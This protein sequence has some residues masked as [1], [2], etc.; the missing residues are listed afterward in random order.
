MY[1]TQIS[2]IKTLFLSAWYPNR[3]D[4]MFGLF[5]FKQA[6]MM[7][8]Y[9]DVCAIFIYADDKIKKTEIIE[10]N[11]NGFVEIKVYYPKSYLKF[12]NVIAFIAAYF[13]VLKYL[14]NK[15]WLPD[16]IHVNVLTRTGFIAYLY[17]VFTKKP[18]II[19]EHWS[20]YLANNNTFKGF[21]RKKITKL[22]VKNASAVMPVSNVLK[23]AMLHHNLKNNN[24]IVVNNIV[25]DFFF[26]N[27]GKQDRKIKR[28]LHIS[29]FDERAKN[30]C[31]L[32]DATKLLSNIRSDFELVLIGTGKDF[33][34]CYQHYKNLGF[35]KKTVIFLG[36]IPPLKVSQELHNADLSVIFSNYETACISVIESLACGVPIIGTPTGIMPETIN[37][38][39]GFIVNFN[40]VIDL[41]NKMNFILNNL[42]NYNHNEIRENAKI[43][44]YES[45][46]KQL[47]EIYKEAL[48][49]DT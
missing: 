33:E 3:Y 48:K 5:A 1:N 27:T 30:I 32:L 18:Y 43:F 23:N 8:N 10:Q 46:S 17:K 21:F 24:Y 38:T 22:V 34:K 4:A 19:T 42:N 20:R 47:L 12:F 13:K 31:G 7:A 41:A 15:K 2:K 26:E 11:I 44:S 37:E 49:I 35:P 9:C 25:D 45:V 39:N 6:K 14:K 36:E 16:I 40:D 28:I 29:C